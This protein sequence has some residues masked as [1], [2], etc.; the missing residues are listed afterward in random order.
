MDEVI[1][2]ISGTGE[3]VIGGD[4]NGHAGCD[5]TGYDRVHGGYGFGIRN[6]EGGKVFDSAIAYD[7]A[8]MILEREKNI[9]L[10]I[11]VEGISLK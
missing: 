5:R 10:P 9:M 8:I 3:T 7:L 6:D 1:Q 2:R 11:K 4:M